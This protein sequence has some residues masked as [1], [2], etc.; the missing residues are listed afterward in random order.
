MLTPEELNAIL[1]RIRNHTTTTQDLDILRQ[2]K[3]KDDGSFTLNIDIGEVK[4]EDVQFGDRITIEQILNQKVIYVLPDEIKTREFN[5]TSPYKGLKKFEL[6]DQNRFF[7]RD[8]FIKELANEL[9][10]TNLILLLGASG[11]G[12]SSVVRAGLMPWLSQRFGDKLISLMFTP[13]QDPFESLYAALLAYYKQPEA[14][15]VREGQAK[16]LKQAVIKLWKPP[17]RWFIFIDQFEEL[18]TISEP[19]R[20][21][22][23]IAGLVQLNETLQ[24]LISENGCPIKIVVTMRADFLAELSPYPSLVKATKKHRP[25]IA[26]MHVDE[27]RQAIE[28]PAAQQGV[29]FETGLEEEIIKDV[30]G[31]AGYLPL[32]QYTLNLLWTME[33]EKGKIRALS[34]SRTLNISTYRGLGGV[35]GALQKHVEQIYQALPAA[36][37]LAA[38]RIFLK[39]VEIGGD[40]ESGTEWK[41]VRRRALRSEFDSELEQRVLVRLINENLLVSDQQS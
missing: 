18:F 1:E 40:E 31:Q 4:G 41:P 36:E 16:T 5:P 20:R 32:L 9:H 37:R 8:Q 14:Q 11:S 12:K 15:I 25:L 30:Q 6:K 29:V 35:R 26:D 22:Q 19:K 2:L 21:D 34:I 23:F 28:Q 17:F 24:Q 10:Q 13:D 27:L 39:L 7:G 33:Q 38:Q 3:R